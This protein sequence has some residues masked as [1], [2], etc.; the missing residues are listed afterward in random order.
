[1]LVALN[2]GKAIIVHSEMLIVA[3][4][5][6]VIMLNQRIPIFLCMQQNLFA[7]RLILKT[8]FVVAL[9]LVSLSAQ[10]GFGFV[11][12]QGVRRGIG[13]MIRT[14]CDDGLIR[15]AIQE[16]NNHFMANSRNRHTTVLATRPFLCHSYPA[17][18]FFVAT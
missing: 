17:R 16:R 5:F 7:T 2:A 1:M 13:R 10:Y 18:A 8:Q 12:R 15:I 3:N 14:T 9:P 11:V 4:H 6:G